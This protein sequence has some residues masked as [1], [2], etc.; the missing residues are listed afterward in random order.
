MNEKSKCTAL[1]I[2]KNRINLFQ[3]LYIVVGGAVK[4]NNL[5]HFNLRAC[6][7]ISDLIKE[8]KETKEAIDEATEAIQNA[9]VSSHHTEQKK[10]E[11]MAMSTN[12]ESNLFDFHGGE[13]PA[14][15][16]PHQQPATASSPLPDM[17]PS[18]P[19]APAQSMPPPENIHMVQ[20][21]SS[22]DQDGGND[23]PEED[24]DAPELFSNEYRQPEPVPAPE[25]A[26]APAMV[27]P[28]QQHYQ[29][30]PTPQYQQPQIYSQPSSAQ[31]SP[32]V[33]RPNAME[34]HNRQSSLGFNPAFIMGGSAEPLPDTTEAGISPAARTKSSSA[35]F[36]YEDEELFHDV[37]EMKKSAERAAAA[38][39]DA[40]AAHQR[41]VNEANELREDADKAEA[42]ARSLKAS[43]AEKK[44]GRFGRSGGD[45]KKILVRIITQH[46]RLHFCTFDSS[47]L[48]HTSSLINPYT[49][50]AMQIEQPK[51]LKTSGSDSLKFRD[52]L[53]MPVPWRWKRGAR[54]ISCEMLLKRQNWK[55]QQRLRCE[56]TR[57]RN[58]RTG[59]HN[60]RSRMLV[61]DTH[62]KDLL[63]VSTHTASL[64]K[65]T[66]N[67]QCLPVVLTDNPPWATG[68]HLKD[69]GN[70]LRAMVSL[71]NLPTENLLVLLNTGKWRLRPWIMDLMP[72]SWAAA[73]VEGLTFRHHSILV[74][75]LLAATMRMDRK[76]VLVVSLHKNHYEYGTHYRYR[77]TSRRLRPSFAARRTGLM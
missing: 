15:A 2:S 55:W 62:I 54:Q 45:K 69:M 44:K 1:R 59:R 50:S 39:R 16:A 27:Q 73:V 9:N 31:P 41:L 22:D 33:G 7:V 25:P 65:A 43:A 36:G 56:I 30:P 37:E 11:A 10:N 6:S 51:M 52:R 49:G 20:T 76:V 48:T 35:D 4:T 61:M 67:R 8:A 13:A 24:D 47:K 5:M 70:H 29:A 64:H 34:H 38:A 3:G 42:T 23:A 26:P 60:L 18:Q 77:G 14:P 53:E 32:N 28:P 40:E 12:F 71:L 66:G 57:K 72:V 19:P 58:K 46:G 17:Y 75:H 63:V 21:V 68:N 74:V